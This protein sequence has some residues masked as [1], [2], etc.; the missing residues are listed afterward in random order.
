MSYN[1]YGRFKHEKE[2]RRRE[3]KEAR[4]V[5]MKL[6]RQLEQFEAGVPIGERSE[7]GGGYAA[8]EK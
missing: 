8:V 4:A 5:K 3:K 7:A 6:R 2:I 1:P